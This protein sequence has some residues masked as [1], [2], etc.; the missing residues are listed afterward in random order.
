MA[1][2]FSLVPMKNISAGLDGLKVKC[3]LKLNGEFLYP[4]VYIILYDCLKLVIGY[5]KTLTKQ[6]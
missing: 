6:M 2:L 1:K 5:I 3:E 4:L